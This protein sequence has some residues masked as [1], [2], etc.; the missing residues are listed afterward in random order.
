MVIL[1]NLLEMNM[2]L[3]SHLKKKKEKKLKS[4]KHIVT[5]LLIYIIILCI[6][7]DLQHYTSNF[8][9]A[10]KPD[11]DQQ[12]SYDSHHG[13]KHLAQPLKAGYVWWN[14]KWKPDGFE[15]WLNPLHSS[16][17]PAVDSIL[18]WLLSISR[19]ELHLYKMT[20]PPPPPH[21][22]LFPF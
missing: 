17:M 22:I 19:C 7:C 21:S 15:H 13:E 12:F 18:Q 11:M 3:F 2:V 14:F 20:P 16:Q 6:I 1:L 5:I 4:P 9:S 8:V 10:L